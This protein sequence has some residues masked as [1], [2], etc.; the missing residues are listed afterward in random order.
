[1]SI[2]IDPLTGMPIFVEDSKVSVRGGGVSRLMATIGLSTP[3]TGIDGQLFYDTDDG[4]LYV[5]ANG[6]WNA[7]SGGTPP[8]ASYVGANAALSLLGP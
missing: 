6:T 5:Y 8:P 2:Q 1:M 3:A 7:I 4:I